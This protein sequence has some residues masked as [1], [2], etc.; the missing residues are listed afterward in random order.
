[1]ADH[2]IEQQIA[3][4]VEDALMNGDSHPAIRKSLERLRYDSW[5]DSGP[6]ASPVFAHCVTAG[7][8]ATFPAVRP[9]DVRVQEGE[10]YIRLALI[11]RLI[12]VAQQLCVVRH[13]FS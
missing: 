2:L 7:D 9:L 8:S 12:H 10:H 6:L 1:M 4:M 3:G 5:V 13:Y 11:E